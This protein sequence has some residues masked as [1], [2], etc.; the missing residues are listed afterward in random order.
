MFEKQLEKLEDALTPPGRTVSLV[1]Y[2]CESEED[3]RQRV[4]AALGGDPRQGDILFIVK[5]MHFG[6]CPP[7]PHAHHDEVKIW[8]CSM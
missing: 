6:P 3:I 7:H 5:V 4:R 1:R 2:D 8:P